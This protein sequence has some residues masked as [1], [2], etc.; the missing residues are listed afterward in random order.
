MW[1]WHRDLPIMRRRLRLEKA[2]HA[3]NHERYE[4]CHCYEKHGQYRKSHPLATNSLR[5]WRLAGQWEARRTN[6]KQR[7]APVVGAA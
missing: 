2:I 7:R 1:R 4:D 3:G 5:A 6:K